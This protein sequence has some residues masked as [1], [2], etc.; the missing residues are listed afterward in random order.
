MIV[1]SWRMVHKVLDW[2]L[3]WLYDGILHT[4]DQFLI[5]LVNKGYDLE[6]LS[7]VLKNHSTVTDDYTAGY[8]SVADRVE[9]KHTGFEVKI[10]QFIVCAHSP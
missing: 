2:Y 7:H 1:F 6:Y 4:A 10:T 8:L 9:I 5:V 3:P